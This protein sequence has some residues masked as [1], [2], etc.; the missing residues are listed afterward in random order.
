MVQL[1]VTGRRQELDIIQCD[2]SLSS[3]SKVAWEM[4]GKGITYQVNR[5]VS[6]VLK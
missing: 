2:V 6:N 1:T 3:P 4:E 5:I